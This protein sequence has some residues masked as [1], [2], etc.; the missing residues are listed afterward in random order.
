M[1][2]EQG[3]I[4]FTRD[5][6]ILFCSSPILCQAVAVQLCTLAEKLLLTLYMSLP[7]RCLR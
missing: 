4:V 6:S 3:L 1:Y 2:G 7:P 5:L